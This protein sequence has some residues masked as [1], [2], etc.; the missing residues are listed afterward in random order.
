MRNESA[1]PRLRIL[2]CAC[3]ALLLS[4]SIG[5]ANAGWISL[6]A[7]GAV[8]Q[9]ESKTLATYLDPAGGRQ[10]LIATR[11]K[12]R[13]CA[14]AEIPVD[15]DKL[16]WGTLIADD[17]ARNLD[18]GVILQGVLDRDPPN[19]SEV[20]PAR[21]RVA[22]IAVS[23]P[24]DA[25]LLPALKAAPFGIEERARANPSANH[26]LIVECKAGARPAGIVLQSPGW[27]LPQG[28]M[29]KVELGYRANAPFTVGIAD[30]ARAARE[31]PLLLGALD[32]ERSTAGLD[33]PAGVLAENLALSFICPEQPARI[34]ISSLR[35]LPSQPRST[36]PGRALWAWR[37]QWW[38]NEPQ[39]LLAELQTARADTV[40]VT[41]PVNDDSPQIS[42][43][44]A[45][46]NFIAEAT[47][48]GIG[49]W[50]VD[51]DPHA[52]LPRVRG[53]FVRRARAYAEYNRGVAENQRLRGVQYDIEPYLVPGYQLATASWLGA[54]LETI[55]LLKAELNMPL[56]LAVPFWWAN[57]SYAGAPFIERLAAY[58]DSLAVMNY[59][60]VPASIRAGAEPFLAWSTRFRRGVRIALEAGAIEDE[61]RR[62][63]RK[64]A[65]GELW[66]V[67][68]PGHTALLLL[69]A[70]AHNPGGAAL[71]RSQSSTFSGDQI[72]FA[73]N[74]Q[75]M[76]ALLPGLEK[77]WS[78]WPGF[79]GIA[80]HGLLP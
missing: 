22:S 36:V 24:V 18:G 38:I 15:I 46:Q 19:V 69:D 74:T 32:A 44:A 42:Q 13:D 45:L 11:E 60:T 4:T 77:S 70:E 27:I 59:R 71:A 16:T 3:A 68:L 63:Y 20:I 67:K 35:I 5:V 41:V 73:R 34:E 8:T 78:A 80:L 49:V 62:H 25:E 30:R 33:L 37:P 53:E 76:F 79:A 39:R 2:R 58:A 17:I 31:E 56:E 1:A 57:E 64:S 9:A 14:S 61:Q 26:T 75:A 40:Y 6:C 7:A 12:P 29:L 66:E 51:G 52:I 10:L 43:R 72:S 21:T 50:A 28:I 55:A 54:Y 47:R 23:T 48:R 65:A